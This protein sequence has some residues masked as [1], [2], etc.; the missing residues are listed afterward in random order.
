M[1]SGR[2]WTSPCRRSARATCTARG[3]RRRLEAVLLAVERFAAG[4]YKPAPQTGRP[5][6]AGRTRP[7]CARSTGGSTGDRPH[8]RR[9]C[10]SCGPPT[11]SPACWTN[12]S[13]RSGS[14]TAGTPRTRCAGAPGELLATRARRGLPGHRRRRGVDPAAAPAPRARAA[15]ATFKLPAILAL[16]DRLPALPEVARPAP[17]CAGAGG[18]WTDIRYR[19]GRAASAS[20]VLLPRRRHEHRPV[21]PAARRLPAGL[22]PPDVACSCSAAP[23]LLLQRH[24]PERHRGRRRPRRRVLGEHQRHGRPGG[25]GPDHHRPAGRRRARRATPRP[26]G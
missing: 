5:G 26:A 25:G 21:P 11:P 24:P 22:R 9:C 12:C 17:D 20:C 8:R 18:T 1:T 6:V 13:A 16:G 3:R 14:C 7:P 4:T 23:G 10:A 19:G 2:R 15:R